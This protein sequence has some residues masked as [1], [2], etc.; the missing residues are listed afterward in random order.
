MSA[1]A[2]IGVLGVVAIAA[3]VALIGNAAA[4]EVARPGCDDQFAMPP[5][6]AGWTV[7]LDCDTGPPVSG[8][9][10]PASKQITVWPRKGASH[11]DVLVT[12]WHEAGHAW[13]HAHMTASERLAVK[14]WRGH[15][16]DEP[17]HYP[18]DGRRVDHDEWAATPAEDF[19]RVFVA[20]LRPDLPVPSDLTP[21][22]ERVCALA[23]GLV[24]REGTP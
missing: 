8:L 20:C 6:P 1:R 5:L 16:E 17:W 21:P 4:D 19:A 10:D 18:W 13:D 14:G 2:G 22:D 9:A 15:G 12:L 11:D 24:E 3:G 23:A 7:Q